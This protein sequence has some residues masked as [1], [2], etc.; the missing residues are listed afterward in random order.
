MINKIA[1]SVADAMAGI[2]D[3]ATVLIGG[4]GTAGIPGELIDGLIEQGA[5]DLTVVN[6]NAGNGDTGLAAL[7]KAGRVRKIICSFPRQADSHV[8]D[9]LYRA[10][11]LELELVPQGNLAERIRA[12]GAGI[13]AFFCP[14]GFGTQLAGERETREIDGKPYVLEYPIRGDVALI[15]AERGDRWG[16]LAYRKAARNFGP[17]MAMASDR[18]IAT[19]HEIAELGEMDPEA[20]VTPGIF[21]KSIVKVDRVATQAGGFK[22][23]A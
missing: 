19:V 3:G 23:A 13:G 20:I 1:R 5:R 6:N 21:V 10:G 18:T 17:V 14:T 22:K 16:N 15:K 8:F 12:A 9:G 4:F 11:T 7:L 2:K